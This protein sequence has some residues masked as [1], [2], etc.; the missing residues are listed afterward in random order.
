MKTS[1]PTRV[2]NGRISFVDED[3]VVY[4]PLTATR[5]DAVKALRELFRN[6]IFRP[7]RDNNAGRELLY[8]VDFCPTDDPN[9]YG[10]WFRKADGELVTVTMHVVYNGPPDP[11]D[12]PRFGHPGGHLDPFDP[13]YVPPSPPTVSPL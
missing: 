3:T 1:E 9:V 8:P 6:G 2:A 12:P 4:V 5:G 10:V 11:N 13:Q 7:T